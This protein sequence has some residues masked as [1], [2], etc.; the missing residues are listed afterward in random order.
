MSRLEF[1]INNVCINRIKN[2]KLIVFIWGKKRNLKLKKMI[3]IHL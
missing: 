2:T 1:I 3:N